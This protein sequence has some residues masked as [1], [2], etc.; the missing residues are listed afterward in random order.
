MIKT[1]KKW[2][3]IKKSIIIREGDNVPYLIRYN[4]LECQWFS[5]KVH[6]ILQSDLDCPHDHPWPFLSIILSGGYIE[7]IPDQ[8][9]ESVYREGWLRIWNS[10]RQELKKIFRVGAILWRPAKWIHRLELRQRRYGSPLTPAT[11]LVITFKKVRDWGFWTRKGW[12][13]Q[14]DYHAINSCE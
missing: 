9:S 6:R 8:D 1:S 5:I 14:E 10:R 3:F 12:V 11:T 2:G 7:C 13:R 4:L